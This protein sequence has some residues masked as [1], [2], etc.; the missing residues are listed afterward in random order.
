MESSFQRCRLRLGLV[1]ASK[2][3]EVTHGA[4]PVDN[5]FGFCPAAKP[6]SAILLTPSHP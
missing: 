3:T 6:S 4:C 1:D 5:S 2:V